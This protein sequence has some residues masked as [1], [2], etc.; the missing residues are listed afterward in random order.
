MAM[1]RTSSSSSTTKIVA[2]LP[3]IRVPDNRITPDIESL[4]LLQLK[5]RVALPSFY[6]ADLTLL[7]NNRG[8]TATCPL[9]LRWYDKMIAITT[10]SLLD[11]A[12]VLSMT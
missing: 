5:S 2:V 3:A 9:G 10:G 7:G 4:A 6:S 8:G 1:S 12:P 11:L